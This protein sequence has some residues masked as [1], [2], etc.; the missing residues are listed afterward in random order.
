MRKHRRCNTPAACAQGSF[1]MP[2]ASP[3]ITGL[4]IASQAQHIIR[5]AFTPDPDDAFA[6]WAIATDRVRVANCTFQLSPR[7]IHEINQAC[8]QEELDIGA[9]S[10]AAW[11]LLYKNY[12][13]LSAGASVGRGYG[14]ALV[15]KSSDQLKLG[16]G[17]IVAIPGAQTTGALLLRLF[18]PGVRTVE[19][20]FD[21]IAAAVHR[22]DADAGVLIHEELLNWRATGL[23]RLACLGERWMQETGMPIPVGLNV[24]HRRLGDDLI[25][26]ISAAIRESMIRANQDCV[27]ARAWAMRYSRQAQAGIA[28][29]FIRMFA[30]DDT[31]QLGDDCLAAL[32]K[33]YAMA[34]ER[35]LIPSIPP[36]E[37]V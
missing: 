14:P 22:G 2:A 31:L 16:A 24:I 34:Y 6:W 21:Q 23:H 7:H 17:A 10:S 32:R 36:V 15:T 1:E 30:N 35:G 3:E 5:A 13:I 19:L 12:K 26:R 33:L 8:I 25:A 20:P 4:R 9:I 37:T 11:P 29:E 28:D 27:E 18:F